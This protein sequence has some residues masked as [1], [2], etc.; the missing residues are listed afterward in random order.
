MAATTKSE[1]ALAEPTRHHTIYL[2]LA[3]GMV[4][5][6]VL[7]RVGWLGSPRSSRVDG[8]FSSLVDFAGGVVSIVAAVLLL[9]VSVLSLRGRR[10]VLRAVMPVALAGAVF[11][12]IRR[13]IGGDVASATAAVLLA[14]A[15]ATSLLAA[16]KMA[17]EPLVQ[18]GQLLTRHGPKAALIAVGV[19]VVE[20]ALYRTT[21]SILHLLFGYAAAATLSIAAIAWLTGTGETRRRDAFLGIIGSM[22][23]HAVLVVSGFVSAITTIGVFAPAAFAFI[24]IGRG[25]WSYAMIV[26]YLGAYAFVARAVNH[27]L[28]SGELTQPLL[29]AVIYFGVAVVFLER[30]TL[31]TGATRERE[32]HSFT[33]PI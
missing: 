3:S 28:P 25:R 31:V 18:L 7:P 24:A 16:R 27:L 9:A 1:E 22:F 21:F 15:A 4:G 17:A 11:C 2:A 32:D 14:I 8:M 19:A 29:Q 6:L 33:A 12:L 26:T 5:V 10:D 20:H 13:L 30:P 23:S